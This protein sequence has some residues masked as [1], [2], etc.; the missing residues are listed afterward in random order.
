MESYF[1][2][3]HARNAAMRNRL[4]DTQPTVCVER[5]VLTTDAYKAHEQEQVVLK[6]AYMLDNVLRNMTLYIDRDTLLLGNQAGADRAAPIFP[7]YAMDWVINELDAFDRRDGDRFTISEENKRILREDIYPYWKGRTLQDKGYAAFPESARLFYDLGII[8][9]EGNIT[10]GDAHIAV[11]YGRVL[12]EGL[13][14]VRSRVLAAQDALK[15]Y[16]FEDLKKSYFYRAI[17]IVLDAVE[18]YA[19]RLAEL[20]EQEAQK[21]TPGRKAELLEMARICRKV[22]MEPA[23]TFHEAVQSVWMLHCVLQIESNGH[24][25]SYG[26]FDQYMLPYYETSRAAGM[27]EEQAAQLAARLYHQQDPQLVP[28]P[29]LCG[30]PALSERDRG[31]PDPGWQ[32]RSQ[33]PELPGAAHGG[34]LSPAPAQPHGALSQGPLGRIYAGGRRADPLRLWHARLQQRRDHH[35]FL[36]RVR[37]QKGGCL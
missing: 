26:R 5:A 29:L 12:R 34:P 19:L 21:A 37:G 30:Q 36:P 7:E 25:L 35:P 31:R 17:L 10:S 24:S 13:A 14:N 16:Q 6:R 23:V 33:P 22:P 18:A 27:G 8:K 11:D 20:A 32:G 9:T 1:G 15:L 3:L 28:H 4:L 2:S